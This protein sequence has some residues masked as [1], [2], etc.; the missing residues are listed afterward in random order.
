M[1]L[2]YGGNI[3][4]LDQAKK[5]FSLGYEKIVINSANYFNK[6]IISDIS[7]YFGSQSVIASLD[8]KKGLLRANYKIFSHNGKKKQN[9][10]LIEFLKY[11]EDQGAGEIL[12]TSIDRDGTWDGY[13][14]DL[15]KMVSNSVN[16]PVIANGGAS[17]IHSIYD[18]LFN[19]NASACAVG[20]MVVYQK[21]DNGVLINFPT[22]DVIEKLFKEYQE[23]KID[24]I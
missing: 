24:K 12:M 2:S 22:P 17:N 8:V 14:I 6:N 19:G 15:L 21:K 4:S 10:R 3:K 1:P 13:D 11:L 9:I 5:I 7:N 23:I 16:L 18:A 20:S